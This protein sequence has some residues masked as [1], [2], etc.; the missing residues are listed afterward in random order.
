M[1]LLFAGRAGTP[2]PRQGRSNTSGA[3]V[4]YQSFSWVDYRCRY[5]CPCQ[6]GLYVIA[7]ARPKSGWLSARTNTRARLSRANTADGTVAKVLEQPLPEVSLQRL[8][9]ARLE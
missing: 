5:H 3:L 6:R 8:P 4:W 2:K 1:M 7:A 9:R